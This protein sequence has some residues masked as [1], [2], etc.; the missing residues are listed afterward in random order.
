M[1]ILGQFNDPP[2]EMSCY[3]SHVKW[4]TYSFPSFKRSNAFG[5]FDAFSATL[6]LNDAT[7]HVDAGRRKAAALEL[8]MVLSEMNGLHS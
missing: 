8:S 7:V 6:V 3:S 4:R 2:F 1:K 5:A